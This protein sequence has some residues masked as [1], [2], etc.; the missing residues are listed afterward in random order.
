MFVTQAEHLSRQPRAGDPDGT[1]CGAK[2]FFG[3]GHSCRYG[4]DKP[5]RGVILWEHVEFGAD[6]LHQ[7]LLVLREPL[8]A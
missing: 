8:H 1:A 5:D 7:L 6:L 2:Q 4:L 3:H